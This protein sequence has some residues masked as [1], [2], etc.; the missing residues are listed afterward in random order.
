MHL[1]PR[2][3]RRVGARHSPEKTRKFEIKAGMVAGHWDCPSPGANS[4]YMLFSLARTKVGKSKCKLRGL[5]QLWLRVLFLTLG[6][7]AQLAL[8]LMGQ[9]PQPL[10]FVDVKHRL[11]RICLSLWMW[12]GFLPGGIQPALQKTLIP[13]PQPGPL[14]KLHFSGQG[15]FHVQEK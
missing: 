8:A 6:L 11:N 13:V 2:C 4:R 5:S 10:L 9:A 15:L 1:V 7:R 3:R 12:H 14:F